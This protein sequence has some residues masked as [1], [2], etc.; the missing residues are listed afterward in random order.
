MTVDTPFPDVTNSGAFGFKLVPARSLQRTIEALGGTREGATSNHKTVLY[1]LNG[2]RL[3]AGKLKEPRGF[4]RLDLLNCAVS[5]LVTDAGIPPI[6]VLALLV[7]HGASMHQQPKSVTNAVRLLKGRDL[8]SERERSRFVRDALASLEAGQP[9]PEPD[10]EP[11]SV[12]ARHNISDAVALLNLPSE[13]ALRV[14][15]NLTNQIAR[16]GGITRELLEAGDLVITK[17]EGAKTRSYDLTANGVLAL[18]AHAEESV[19]PRLKLPLPEP[20]PERDDARA[21]ETATLQTAP[22]TP[23]P[24]PLAPPAGVNDDDEAVAAALLAL[25][26]HHRVQ[27][28]TRGLT[29]DVRATLLKLAEAL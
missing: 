5:G 10:P 6:C 7:K 28:R 16:G 9:S 1:D 24:P 19:L 11:E 8:T 14:T 27:P 22:A 29:L 12:P 20:A 2:V 4:I 26:L 18:A 15:K 23:T 25:C 3:E 13:H 21:T 17:P